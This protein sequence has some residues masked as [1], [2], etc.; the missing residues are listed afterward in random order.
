VNVKVKA[1]DNL[2]FKKEEEDTNSKNELKI[3]S[4]G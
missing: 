1:L 3:N 2:L 4:E